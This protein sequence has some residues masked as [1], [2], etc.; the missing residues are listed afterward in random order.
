MRMQEQRIRCADQLTG[1]QRD[2]IVK[3]L[4]RDLLTGGPGGLDLSREMVRVLAAADRAGAFDGR[5]E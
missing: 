5:E 3:L 1:R 2:T 4:T